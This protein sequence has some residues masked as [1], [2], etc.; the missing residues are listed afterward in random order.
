MKILALETSAKSVSVAVTEDGALLSQAY[1]NRGLT[2]SV[3]LMPL[4]DGML[5]VSYTHLDVYKRQPRIRGRAPSWTASSSH[6]SL[7]ASA[8]IST[9]W[10]RLSPPS[11]TRRGFFTPARTQSAAIS[12]SRSGLTATTIRCV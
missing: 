2:H 12:S 10:A 8:A 1:Q 7:A 11:T 3:T 4:L 6:R 5:P 9:D